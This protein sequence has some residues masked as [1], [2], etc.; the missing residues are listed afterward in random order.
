MAVFLDNRN[1]LLHLDCVALVM[2]G[3]QWGYLRSNA[4]AMLNSAG[5]H[6][7]LHLNHIVHEIRLRHGSYRSF[8][9]DSSRPD[10]RTSKR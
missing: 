8:K 10:Q 7:D 9:S 1:T 3:P 5:L 6:G 4:K 2:S